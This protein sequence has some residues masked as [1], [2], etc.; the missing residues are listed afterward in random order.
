MN[1]DAKKAH[2][3]T[4]LAT[5]LS[6]LNSYQLVVQKKK[7]EKFQYYKKLKKKMEDINYEFIYIIWVAKR[8][9]CWCHR[10]RLYSILGVVM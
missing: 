1:R 9:D 3:E 2:L 8:D 5:H 10:I 4:T 6:A 7:I